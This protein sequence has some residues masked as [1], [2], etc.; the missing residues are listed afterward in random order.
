[1]S[2]AMTSCF[3]GYCVNFE[4]QVLRAQGV[5][6]FTKEQRR[7]EV[8]ANMRYEGRD[9]TLMILRLENDAFLSTFLQRHRWENQLHPLSARSFIDDV[10][11]GIIASAN[12]IA[13]KR[14][15][16]AVQG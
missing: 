7:Y 12:K 4:K 14:S 16:A 11:I 6:C 13:E 5:Q 8:F 1:M 10:R 3:H 2:E 15:F 9:T